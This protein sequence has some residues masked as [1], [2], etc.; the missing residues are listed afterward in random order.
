MTALTYCVTTTQ[1]YEWLER[2][3]NNEHPSDLEILNTP[4]FFLSCNVPNSD[5]AHV[6]YGNSYGESFDSVQE[7]YDIV[8][9]N[10]SNLNEMD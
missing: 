8:E 10:Y 1:I 5:E 6:C 2:F 3:K 4:R 9:L 7:V